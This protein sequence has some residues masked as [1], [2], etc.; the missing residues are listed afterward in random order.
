[1]LKLFT[2]FLCITIVYCADKNQSS[3]NEISKLKGDII[4]LSKEVTYLKKNRH[5][6]THFIVNSS[7]SRE[8]ESGPMVKMTPNETRDNIYRFWRYAEFIDKKKIEK[9]FYL[10]PVEGHVSILKEGVYFIYG[11]IV[12][13][14]LSGRYSWGL[15]VG[16]RERVKC[17]QTEQLR[18]H[19]EYDPSSHGVYQSCYTG[20][21]VYLRKFDQLT[22]RCM[23]GSRTILTKPDFTFWGIIAM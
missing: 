9:T 16:D 4:K 3:I 23:Y 21:L 14:D 10:N 7:I 2:L 18:E 5:I 13:H 15:Y 12:Y 20:Q 11:Q 22:L 19:I 8:Y 17:I 1:M 6:Y